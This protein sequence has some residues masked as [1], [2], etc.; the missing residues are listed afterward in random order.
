MQLR[1]FLFTI[2]LFILPL[3]SHAQTFSGTGGN[4]TNGATIQNCFTINATGLPTAINSSFGLAQLCL[5]ITHPNTDELE[6]LLTAPD[7]TIVPISI[8]NGG[9]G[10]NYSNTCFTGTAAN[11]I[12]FGSSPFNGTY[13][14]EG[15]L[16]AVNNGQN[17][18]GAWRLCITDRRTA[19]NVGTLNSWNLTFNNT[20]AP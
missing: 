14:P 15:Y 9:S 19:S 12:K 17:P 16:G 4:I 3:L 18:N 1:N 10:N 7:G 5:T 13:L 2:A 6:I 11:H 8:Q 20:P